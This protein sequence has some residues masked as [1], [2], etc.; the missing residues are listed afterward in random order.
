VEDAS[1]AVH[2][3]DVADEDVGQTHL[4]E[5]TTGGGASP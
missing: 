1:L 2:Q 3:H 5:V 4:I